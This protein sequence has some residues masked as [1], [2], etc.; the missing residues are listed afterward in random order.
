MRDLQKVKYSSRVNRDEK[1]LSKLC[2]GYKMWK[3]YGSSAI[4]E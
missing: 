3:S 4:N 2:S 1:K